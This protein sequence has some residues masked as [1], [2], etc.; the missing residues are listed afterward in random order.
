MSRDCSG[1]NSQSLEKLITSQRAR[2]G[3][4]AAVNSAAVTPRSNKSIAMD[5]VR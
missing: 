1:G 4:N 3:R 5:S 2:V